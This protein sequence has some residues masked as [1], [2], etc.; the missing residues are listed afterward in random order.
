[1]AMFSNWNEIGAILGQGASYVPAG[2]HSGTDYFL[3]YFGNHQPSF[4]EFNFSEGSF[5]VDIIDTW[6]MTISCFA[7]RASGPVRVS[8][9]RKPYMAIRLQR[10]V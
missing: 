4:H 2:G 1:M 7:E 3:F 10:A 9:P 8:L 5:R 6:N